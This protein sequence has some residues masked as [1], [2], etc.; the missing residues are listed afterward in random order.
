[1]GAMIVVVMKE[2]QEGLLAAVGVVI[3]LELRPTRVMRF[4]RTARPFH[5]SLACK[6]VCVCA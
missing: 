6:G 1:M 4:A 2:G 3:G 5:S